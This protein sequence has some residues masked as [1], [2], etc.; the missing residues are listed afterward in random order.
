[1][2]FD[3]EADLCRVFA[4]TLPD[5]WIC[6]NETGGFDILLVHRSGVQIGVEAKLRLNPKVLSQVIE[7]RPHQSHVG[8]DFRAV[9]IGRGGGPD[10]IKLA[11]ALGITVMT[12][13][14]KDW[15]KS[16]TVNTTKSSQYC[17]SPKLP[18]VE[19]FVA[20]RWGTFMNWFDCVPAQRV[21]LPEFVPD[22]PAGVSSPVILGHWKIQA[23]RACVL[24][25][26]LGQITRP[27]FKAL[28]IDPGR[29]MN[30]IWLDKGPT[31]GVWVK[32]PRFPAQTFRHQHPL[33]YKQVENTFDDWSRSLGLVKNR[34]EVPL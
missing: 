14:R 27:D 1:M 4:T 30:G 5:D 11:D 31:R 33:V 21:E 25:E 29:W 26:K 15:N 13:V 10:L 8:P 20:R 9:L 3:T 28:G 23:I 18:D 22:V 19:P 32:G 6:Y 16:F 2:T 34:Q 12:V 7:T 17:S 24:V